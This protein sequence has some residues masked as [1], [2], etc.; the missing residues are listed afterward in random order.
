[1]IDFF[2]FKT[3]Y[4]TLYIAFYVVFYIIWH[5]RVT[6]K[7]QSPNELSGDISTTHGTS[8]MDDKCWQFAGFCAAY[9]P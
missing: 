6:P 1:M 9:H 7:D 4:M 8:S 3:L 5:P 2:I